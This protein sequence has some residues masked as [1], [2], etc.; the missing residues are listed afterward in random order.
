[1]PRT[2]GR[3]GYAADMHAREQGSTPEQASDAAS[4]HMED[5]LHVLPR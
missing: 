4:A 2:T 3:T 1:M 5:V